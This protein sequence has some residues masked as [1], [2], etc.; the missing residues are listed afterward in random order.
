[1]RCLIFA[2]VLTAC[3]PTTVAS[4]EPAASSQT[5]STKVAPKTMGNIDIAGFKAKIDAN[6]VA[7]LFD[8]RTAGEFGGGHVKGAV[9]VPLQNLAS[10]MSMFEPY[11]GDTIYLICQSGGRSS[12]AGKTLAAAGYDVVNVQGGTGGWVAAGHAV[13]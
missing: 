10:N 7:A 4:S 13:D 5:G 9:N 2:L 6:E 12:R 8:V 3:G 11:K 1:M